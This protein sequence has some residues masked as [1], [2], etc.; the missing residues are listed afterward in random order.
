M[1]KTAERGEAAT[2]PKSG[3]LVRVTTLQLG[4]GEPMLTEFIV[5]ESDP[6]KAEQIIRAVMAPNEEV[7]AVGPVSA[8]QIEA[9]GLKP[10]DFTHSRP[11]P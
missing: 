11:W 6:L 9:F 10:G 5:A 3:F 4:G 8:E 1:D 7:N 2:A